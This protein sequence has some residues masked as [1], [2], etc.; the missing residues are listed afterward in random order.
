MNI[1][2]PNNTKEIIDKI[3]LAIGRPIE[4]V[5][6]E[7]GTPCPASGCDLDPIANTSTNSFC[8]TCSGMYWIPE[9]G[10]YTISG[11]IAWGKDEILK[12]ESGGQWFSGEAGA[13]IEYSD[14]N[15]TILDKTN[16]VVVD[17]KK[18]EIKKK[19]FRGVKALNRILLDLSEFDKED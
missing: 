4:F 18:L 9:Y 5:T 2:F 7:S 10:S 13:Q 6:T 11:H 15:I 17:G 14:T 3:R 1:T 12:W 8:L 16:Y 19:L